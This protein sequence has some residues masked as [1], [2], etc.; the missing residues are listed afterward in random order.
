MKEIK[1]LQ[2]FTQ[3]Q[4]FQ[5]LYDTRQDEYHIKTLQQILYNKQNIIILIQTDENDLF[6]SFHASIS[7]RK[8]MQQKQKHSGWIWEDE[9]KEMFLFTLHNHLNPNQEPQCFPLKMNSESCLC[10]Y[11]SENH[12][13]IVFWICYCI[14]L[15]KP[16][17]IPK[18]FIFKDIDEY[19]EM[20]TPNDLIGKSG[21]LETFSPKRVIV[22]ECFN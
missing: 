21:L 3:F 13:E 15:L 11:P 8:M 10:L 7:S 4:S 19:F 18:S 17:H 1:Y 2:Q 20:K 6:G 9:D 14:N 16:L 22:L 12:F 5:I